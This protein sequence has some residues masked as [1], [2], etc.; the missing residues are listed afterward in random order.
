MEHISKTSAFSF[1]T[2]HFKCKP[3]QILI[4]HQTQ[5]QPESNQSGK[6]PV[7]VVGEG[8]VGK[9]GCNNVLHMSA[10]LQHSMESRFL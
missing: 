8:V 7:P 4:S 5:H 10:F 6:S 9:L 2:V 1:L 3:G